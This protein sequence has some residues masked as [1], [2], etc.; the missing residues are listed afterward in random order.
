MSIGPI[1]VVGGAAAGGGRRRV[2]VR[3]AAPV[4]DRGKGGGVVV[5]VGDGTGRPPLAGRGRSSGK[6]LPNKG[7]PGA[8][9]LEKADGLLPPCV[10]RSQGGRERVRNPRRG[11]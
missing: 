6:G 5:S 2:L 10:Q 1:F 11:D 4:V 3:Q 7:L 9:I 8:S